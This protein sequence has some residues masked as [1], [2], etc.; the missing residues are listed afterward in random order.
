MKKALIAIGVN[1]TDGGFEPL[2]GAIRDAKAMYSW[3]QD[4]GFE[5]RL[6]V[7]ERNKKVRAEDIFEAV[8]EFVDKGTFSQI[9]VYFSGHGV[10]K[11]PQ[12]ELWLLSGA[13]KNPNAVINVSDSLHN[14]RGSGIEHVV[15]ISDACRSLPADMQQAVLG[16]GQVVFAGGRYGTEPTE[17]D[18][19]YAT[20]PGDVALELPAGSGARDRGLM[21]EYLLDALEGNVP[22]VVR[23][24]QHDGEALEVVHCRPLKTWLTATVKQAA[25]AIALHLRQVPEFRIE[26]DVPK[27][28]AQVVEPSSRADSGSVRNKPRDR[29]GAATRNQLIPSRGGD[30]AA[31]RGAAARP[32]AMGQNEDD[33]GARRQVAIDNLMSLMERAD[34][35]GDIVVVGN[36][37][38]YVVSKS[39]CDVTFDGRDSR[40]KLE[41]S[42]DSTAVR[43]HDGTGLVIGLMPGFRSVVVVEKGR[44]LA[45][46][47]VPIDDAAQARRASLSQW[48]AVA[49]IDAINARFSL[50]EDETSPL[51]S[52]LRSLKPN[53]SRTLNPTLAVY[54]GYEYARMGKFED[55]RRLFQVSLAQQRAIPFDLYLQAYKAGVRETDHIR[56]APRMPMLTQGWMSL[57]ELEERMPDL[58]RRARQHML[59]SMW[60]TFTPDGMDHLERFV[61]EN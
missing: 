3:G 2:K 15:F 56:V 13:P 38:Q 8:T 55:V 42:A 54:A 27:Y 21:T 59:P 7:D 51:V 28:L 29:T 17:L 60:A 25:A 58:L 40:I 30:D 12:C 6:F 5:C 10:L 9:I 16:P 50:D 36:Q 47:Y 44:V 57:G 46:N 23:P 37:I 1:K 48:Q 14:A 39:R 22:E 11:A 32:Q 4:Q 61:L 41:A 24:L 20:I 35:A 49:A 19:F 18:V 26:S 43:L 33:D 53:G 45:V 34:P 52:H 31:L